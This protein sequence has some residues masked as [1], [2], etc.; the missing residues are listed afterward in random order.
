MKREISR[1]SRLLF[2]AL[3]GLLPFSC[4][5]DDDE[6]GAGADGA[7]V[8]TFTANGVS[9]NMVKVEGGTFTMGATP[10]QGDDALNNEKPAH[11]VTLSTYYMGQTE[12]TQ[13][14]WEAVMADNPSYLKGD[15]R[16]VEQVSW[17]DCQTFLTALN[18]LTG[19]AFRL[20]TEAEWEYAARGG[21]NSRGY[22]YAGADT[23]DDVACYLCDSTL[24]VAS[25]LPN[26]IGL[27]DMSGNVYEWCQDWYGSYGESPLTDPTGP[28][29]G[30]FRVC[31]GGGWL[32]KAKNCRVSRRSGAT[33]DYRMKGI[34]LRLAL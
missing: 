26:E 27:Y 31:R 22:K 8:K 13:A 5:A 9:F 21:K 24:D 12:V 33:P 18:A 15:N 11:L 3:C 19:Q 32:D 28:P 6:G 29:S 25:R 20:P 1:I 2:V 23:P 34:G 14:L 10:E 17:E 4:D 30:T 16:P 7:A